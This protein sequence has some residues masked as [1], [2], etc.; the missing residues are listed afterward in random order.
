MPDAWTRLDANRRFAVIAIAAGM[1][2]LAFL[3]MKRASTPDYVTLFRELDLAEVGNITDQLGKA[4]IQYQLG[5]GGSE[6]R[7]P[8][9]DAARARVLLAKVGLPAN[10]RPG[11]ELFDKP[12]WGMTDFTQHITYRRALEGE[13]ARTIG[14]LRGVTRAQVHLALPEESPIR[15]QQRPPEAAVVVSLQPN[16]S[17]SQDQVRGITQLV[18]GSVEQMTADHVVVLDDSGRPL[19]GATDTEGA[20]LTAHQLDLEQGVEQHL[21]TKVEQL[22][23]SAVGPSDVRVQVAARL[24]FDQVERTIDTYDP[25][26]KV[27]S[28]EQR[29]QTSAD[30]SAG[31]AAGTV[32]NNTY[33]NSRKLEKIIG[34]TG[35]VTRLTV[36]V[37]LN[38][39]ALKADQAAQ[40]DQRTSL[41][42]LVRNAIGIDSTRGDQLSVVAVPFTDP[43]PVKVNPADTATIKASAID[44]LSRFSIPAVALL[45]V[46]VA[47]VLGLRMLKGSGAPRAIGAGTVNPAVAGGI[48][49]LTISDAGGLRTRVQAE[50]AS[51][52][53]AAARVI[54]AWL[55]STP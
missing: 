5:N 3:L 7:V 26:G 6:V 1:V 40:D 33:L 29:S 46:I 35:N 17:L 52:P 27:L 20:A 18:A 15:A 16:T 50:S 42:Q 11:L 23:S 31:D 43:V 44:T 38:S 53:D 2:L 49:Q 32:I 45:A 21:A 22:L 12:S 54:R 48:D 25:N 19:T 24:N 47:L 10:G 9:P 37:M 36:S 28:N 34:E 55:G 39:R 8:L 14:T 13:L 4:S 51:S 30:S 41:A